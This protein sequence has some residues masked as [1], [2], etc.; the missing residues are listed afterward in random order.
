MFEDLLNQAAVNKQV[1]TYV[2]KLADYFVNTPT[3]IGLVDAASGAGIISCWSGSAE[4]SAM[5]KGTLMLQDIEVFCRLT[6]EKV[7]SL[8]QQ[9]LMRESLVSSLLQRSESIFQSELSIA[10]LGYQRGFQK[11]TKNEKTGIFLA[12]KYKKALKCKIKFVPMQIYALEQIQM[13]FFLSFWEFV[14]K[15]KNIYQEREI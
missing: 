15:E 10:V 11:W 2:S 8:R 5:L 14:T 6:G 12:F 13:V 7:S 9:G 1:N 4:L 3:T